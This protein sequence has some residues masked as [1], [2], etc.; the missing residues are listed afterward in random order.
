MRRAA[1]GDVEIAGKLGHFA[2]Q[3]DEPVVPA[4]SDARLALLLDRPAHLV[5][6]RQPVDVGAVLGQPRQ[7]MREI[8]QLVG[9]HVD[10]A[11]FP[12]A[13]GR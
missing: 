13:R 6:A 2:H 5:A 8:L 9:D 11:A 7:K 10:D 4:A 12:P 3:P 1:R